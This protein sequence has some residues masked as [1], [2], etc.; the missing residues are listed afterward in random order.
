MKKK[1]YSLTV[2]IVALLT[3]AASCN[4]FGSDSDS[5]PVLP[6]GL[7]IQGRIGSVNTSTAG[8]GFNALSTNPDW[9]IVAVYWGPD[10][11]QPDIMADIGRLWDPEDS[12]TGSD[13]NF[14]F[15]EGHAVIPVASDGSFNWEPPENVQFVLFAVDLN[16]SVDPV[17]GLLGIGSSTGLVW[18][19]PT[20]DLLDGRVDLGSFTPDTSLVWESSVTLEELA[21]DG[22]VSNGDL[23]LQVAFF[24]DSISLLKS[25]LSTCFEITRQGI[26]ERDF[27]IYFVLNVNGGGTDGTTVEQ[28]EAGIAPTNALPQDEDV[29]YV[30]RYVAYGAGLNTS[31]PIAFKPPRDISWTN[32]SGGNGT[33]A[34]GSFTEFPWDDEYPEGSGVFMGFV[35]TV[36]GETYNE[37]FMTA[38]HAESW[39]VRIGNLERGIVFD[40]PVLANK[41]R[42]TGRHWLPI[43]K[44]QAQLNNDD[45]HIEA[46]T[47]T[48]HRY[49]DNAMEPLSDAIMARIMPGFLL[50]IRNLHESTVT[51][52]TA[53][54]T[55]QFNP[56]ISAASLNDI[57]ITWGMPGASVLPTI[58]WDFGE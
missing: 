33:M 25:Q 45:T 41:P 3:V 18:Q 36:D 7:S 55:V 43:P 21:A 53:A 54:T 22:G 13:L 38:T 51:P 8:A 1:T 11:R 17:R 24:D 34:S 56:P 47:F 58:A 9:V 20:T 31:V 14:D 10:F 16:D 44:L 28:I 40:S 29:G 15:W 49:R 19:S 46:L 23:A 57:A 42:T 35:G 32:G 50:S 52:V 4:F 30:I 48:W 5:D 2:L 12:F 27:R 39:R 37:W 26:T 6:A